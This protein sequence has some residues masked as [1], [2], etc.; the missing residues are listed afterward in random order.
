MDESFGTLRPVRHL[1][2]KADNVEPLGDV[3]ATVRYTEE[4]GDPIIRVIDSARL[5][6]T[7]AW[8]PADGFGLFAEDGALLSWWQ[9]MAAPGDELV[10][11]EG[12]GFRMAMTSIDLAAAEAADAATA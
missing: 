11:G 4:P 10:L 2:G 1:G 12:W 8:I 9:L 3:E 6:W 5:P 7:E